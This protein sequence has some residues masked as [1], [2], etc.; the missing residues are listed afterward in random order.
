MIEE[1]E[2]LERAIPRPVRHDL[3]TWRDNRQITISRIT[4]SHQPAEPADT[5]IAYDLQTRW[6]DHKPLCRAALAA[7]QHLQAQ[8][9][10]LNAVEL[11]GY[12]LPTPSCMV[13]RLRRPASG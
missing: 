1:F 6:V 12:R 7:L 13:G 9:L 8:D 2:G 5:E 3:I 4:L 10:D 11:S